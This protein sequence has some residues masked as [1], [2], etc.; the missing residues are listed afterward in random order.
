MSDVITKPFK[1]LSKLLTQ[2][3]EKKKKCIKKF[4]SASSGIS[5]PSGIER[6][7][8]AVEKIKYHYKK[9]IILFGFY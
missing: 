4:S 1:E 3:N 2:N 9:S 7:N 8:D 6:I 5:Y